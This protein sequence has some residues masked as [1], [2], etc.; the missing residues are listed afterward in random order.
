MAAKVEGNSSIDFTPVHSLKAF[1]I[2][3]MHFDSL[4]IPTLSVL[5]VAIYPLS[6]L[7]WQH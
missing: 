6:I 4:P 2:D 7:F 5:H 3:S 1:H